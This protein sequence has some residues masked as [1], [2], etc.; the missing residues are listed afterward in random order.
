M[1]TKTKL[2]VDNAPDERTKR[3]LL[4]AARIKR[5]AAPMIDMGELLFPATT[6]KHVPIE[7]R[8]AAYKAGTFIYTALT[9][10][11][12]FTRPPKGR[13]ARDFSN[14]IDDIRQTFAKVAP[15]QWERLGEFREKY[16]QWIKPAVAKALRDCA[17]GG[18][19]KTADGFVGAVCDAAQP[20]TGA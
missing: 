15:R 9:N 11:H 4:K 16:P 13:T 2:T 3:A 1:T 20:K 10:P 19:I 5:E 8:D 6:I 12:L 18:P 7:E 14:D 17:R